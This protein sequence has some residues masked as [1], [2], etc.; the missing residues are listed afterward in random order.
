MTDQTTIFTRT[1]AAA[2]AIRRIIEAN[3]RLAEQRCT[4]ATDCPGPHIDGCHAHPCTGNPDCPGPQ[5]ID[6]CAAT[7]PRP[8]RADLLAL[9]EAYASAAGQHRTAR[10]TTL[11]A[12]RSLVTGELDAA[13]AAQEKALEDEQ[14][15]LRVLRDAITAAVPA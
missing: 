12:R 3:A 14:A 8:T 2:A 10:V 6:G 5:H 7:A 15:A 11:Q 9:V 13:L 1:Q 4:G